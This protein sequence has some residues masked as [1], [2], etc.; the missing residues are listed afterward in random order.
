MMQVLFEYDQ[1]SIKF[2]L[3]SSDKFQIHI[4]DQIQKKTIEEF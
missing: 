4:L 1:V 2:L 3:Q